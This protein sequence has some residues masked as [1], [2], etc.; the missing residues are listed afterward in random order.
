MGKRDVAVRLPVRV[1]GDVLG[2]DDFASKRRGPAG[3]G[4]GADAQAVDG[5]VVGFRQVGRRA[6]AD[7]LGPLPKYVRL[8]LMAV[9][10]E[11]GLRVSVTGTGEVRALMVLRRE[12][13]L[14]VVEMGAMRARLSGTVLSGTRGEMERLRRLLVSEG[15]SASLAPV[16]GG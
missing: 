16:A 12:L 2:D 5:A 1:G 7:G 6:E 9:G 11:W 4:G 3:A 15:V 8:E 13:G 14:S 10:G